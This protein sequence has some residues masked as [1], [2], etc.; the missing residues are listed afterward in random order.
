MAP[1]IA[2][3]IEVAFQH[4][5]GVAGRSRLRPGCSPGEKLERAI[6]VGSKAPRAMLTSGQG[7]GKE[8]DS[9]ASGFTWPPKNLL[10]SR[11]GIPKSHLSILL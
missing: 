8:K 1:D 10:C 5:W 6:G 2:E 9:S 7:Q 11:P 3:G 4:G